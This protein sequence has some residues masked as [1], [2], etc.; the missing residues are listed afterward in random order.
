MNKVYDVLVI[1]GG[2]A[3]MFFAIIAAENGKS[4]GIMEKNEAPGKKILATGNG[5]CNFTNTQWSED[6][7]RGDKDFAYNIYNKFDYKKTLEYFEE[8]GIYHYERN[9]YCYPYSRQAKAVNDCLLHKLYKLGV[10]IIN[11]SYVLEIYKDDEFEVKVQEGE[12]IKKYYGQNIVLATGG[13]SYKSLGSDGSGYTIAKKMGHSITDLFPALVKLNVKENI[14]ALEGVR[15]MAKVTLKT[16]NT[17]YSSRG[18]IIFGKNSIS[19]I[20]VFEI[21]R[22]CGEANSKGEEVS[23]SIDFFPDMDREELVNMLSIRKTNISEKTYRLLIGLLNDKIAS[24]Y[25]NSKE[26]SDINV[27]VSKLKEFTFVG[28]VPGG[29]DM[30]QVSAGG[31]DTKEIDAD[32]MESKIVKGLYFAGEIVNVDGNCGG[33][34]LQWAWSSAYVA[35]CAIAGMKGQ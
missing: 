27:L 35:A 23:L 34:N 26:N 20:P 18:E 14:K 5:K 21:S 12:E 11:N 29:F 19:G 22:Y 3:G 13:K 6:S 15:V 4:V 33:Y 32:T 7:L 30:A 16:A 25:S 10:D 17:M 8:L 31:V 1:G 24:Y 9:G 2:A 28:V